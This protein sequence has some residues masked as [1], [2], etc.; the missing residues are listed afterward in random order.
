LSEGEV[1]DYGVLDQ[2][3]FLVLRYVVLPI[4]EAHIVAKA[5][6]FLETVGIAGVARVAVG[7]SAGLDLA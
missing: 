1:V 3:P 4:V 2:L 6:D 7:Q 5:I